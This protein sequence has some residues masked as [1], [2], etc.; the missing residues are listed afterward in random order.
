MVVS[1]NSSGATMD[2]RV[3]EF[4]CIMPLAN[5]PSVLQ[6]GILSRE[7]ASKIEHESAAMPEIQ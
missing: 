7:R 5:V 4:Q 3:R 2:D 1:S 6:R